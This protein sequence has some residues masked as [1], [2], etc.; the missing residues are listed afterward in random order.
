ML[1][2]FL[3]LFVACDGGSVDDTGALV[4]S[5]GQEWPRLW[6]NEF[7]ASNQ[8]TLEDSSGATPD[9]LE[10]YNPNSDAVSLQDWT[11]TDDLGEFDKHTL[12]DLSISAGGFLLLYAGGTPE[13]GEQHVSFKLSAAGEELGLYAP[14]GQA[15]DEL[16]FG[17]QEPDVSTARTTDGGAEWAT[18][19]DATPGE[20][21]EG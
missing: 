2:L 20:S 15:I 7:M 14:G 8:G 6:I 3:G 21:N 18:T 11:I 5:N 19:A 13:L 10:I 4:D 1:G 12:G 17:P 16:D 9:W